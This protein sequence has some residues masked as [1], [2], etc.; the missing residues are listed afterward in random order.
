MNILH[1]ARRYLVGLDSDQL[2]AISIMLME[3]ISVNGISSS[4][5]GRITDHARLGRTT[6]RLRR[7]V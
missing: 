4:T 1:H 6:D 7:D 5:P 3:K 2:P